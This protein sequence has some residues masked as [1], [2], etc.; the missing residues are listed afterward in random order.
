M[1]TDLVD[2]IQKLR[3]QQDF[4]INAAR[5]FLEEGIHA[6]LFFQLVFALR[7]EEMQSI[8]AKEFPTCK[9]A[10]LKT[11]STNMSFL[12]IFLNVSIL[13]YFLNMCK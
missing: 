8:F 3:V 12:S 4:N 5:L 6:V 10:V 13:I 11:Y 1:Y 9:F 2:T 7:L